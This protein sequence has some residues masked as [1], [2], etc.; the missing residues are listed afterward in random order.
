[1][2]SLPDSTAWD[3]SPDAAIALQRDLAQRVERQD[4]FGEITCVAGIDCSTNRETNQGRAAVVVLDFATL[5]QEE[6]ARFEAPLRMPYV[7]GLLS[8]REIPLIVGALA[9][10]RRRPDLLLVDG[11]GIA[12]PRRLGIAAHLGVLLDVPAIGC[13]KSILRGRHEP[14]PDVVGARAPMT[15]RGE[16]VGVAL[17]TRQ[18]ANPIYIS[19]GHR[20]SLTSAV[21]LVEACHRAPYRL[22]EPTRLAHLRASEPLG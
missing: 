22:P 3:L 2:K 13:A 18:R 6:V 12:H 16:I 4:R 8:F 15:D 1:M 10:L 7:P 17:R 9:R 19:I 20:V 21:S 14:L 5:A 11:Q